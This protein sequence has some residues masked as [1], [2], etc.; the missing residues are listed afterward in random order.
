MALSYGMVHRIW[1]A[2]PTRNSSTHPPPNTTLIPQTTTAG[3]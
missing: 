1:Q 3:A 2:Q